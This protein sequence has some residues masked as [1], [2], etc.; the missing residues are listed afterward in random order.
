[1]FSKQIEGLLHEIPVQAQVPVR[2]DCP[3]AQ[4]EQRRGPPPPPQS[5]G[6]S[7]ASVDVTQTLVFGSQQPE[8]PISQMQVWVAPQDWPLAQSEQRFPPSPQAPPASPI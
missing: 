5:L 6:L 4:I 1:L 3:A 8:Q 7:Y 2:H